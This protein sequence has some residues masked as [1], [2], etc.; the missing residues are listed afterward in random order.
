MKQAYCAP[1]TPFR[2]RLTG[3]LENL[4]S[5]KINLRFIFSLKQKAP[6]DNLAGLFS[7][8]SFLFSYI[9][10]A[11]V[12]IPTAEGIVNT[13]CLVCDRGARINRLTA[14]ERSDIKRDTAGTCKPYLA[15]RAGTEFGIECRAGGTARVRSATHSL[16]AL[17][18]L[19]IGEASRTSRIGLG[20]QGRIV[21]S[22]RR[23][24]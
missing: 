16:A 4:P 1:V 20:C 18:R 5:R 9:T 15:G 14:L 3:I 17:E 6:Q 11:F 2:K 21:N 10:R 8:N 12:L 22:I 23:I 13:T 7:F 19:A 24:N